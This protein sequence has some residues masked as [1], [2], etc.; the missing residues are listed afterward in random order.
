MNL[1]RLLQENSGGW[2]ICSAAV[3]YAVFALLKLPVI[4]SNKDFLSFSDPLLGVQIKSVLVAACVIEANTAY[5]L[6]RPSRKR[7]K[8]L[9]IYFLAAFFGV[10]HGVL[11]LLNVPG[12]CSC[13]GLLHDI[14]PNTV[15]WQLVADSLI[16]YLAFGSAL[17]FA[18]SNTRRRSV[19]PQSPMN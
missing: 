12:A 17:A 10:Y 2:F 13:F 19:E 8:L 15:P 7:S 18:S 5:Y 11:W 9:V 4:F 6:I 3:I 14:G 16:V 1:R